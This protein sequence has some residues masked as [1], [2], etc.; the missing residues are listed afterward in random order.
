MEVGRRRGGGKHDREKQWAKSS[1]T[2]GHKVCSIKMQSP[3]HVGVAKCSKS[4]KQTLA[5][6]VH[7]LP[8]RKEIVV[9]SPSHISISPA[10]P[11][12]ALHSRELHSE[13]V[14][15]KNCI[16]CG[17]RRRRWH[18][19]NFQSSSFFISAT[20]CWATTFTVVLTVALAFV[21]KMQ[22]SLALELKYVYASCK[23]S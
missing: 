19:Q 5:R 16:V 23:W 10:W 3:R 21:G 15:G 7:K 12:L 22:I 9:S 8:S 14:R 4:S 2:R 13:N 1:V 11:G 6:R 17:S 20:S 18:S